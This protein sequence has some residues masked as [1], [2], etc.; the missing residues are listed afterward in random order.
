MIPA[1]GDL[2]PRRDG[3]IVVEV[4]M[5]AG[6]VHADLEELRDI[7][8]RLEAAE[9]DGNVAYIGD[10]MA[11]D[12]VIMVPNQDVREGK[13]E[14]ARFIGDILPGL[15]QHF[16]RRIIYVS[17]EVRVMA[18]GIAFDRGWFR[19]TAVPRSGGDATESTGKYF[20]LYTSAPGGS[21]KLF[22]LVHVLDEE[23]RGDGGPPSVMRRA[24]LAV[25]RW[26]QRDR[27]LPC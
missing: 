17:D 16:D 7:H 23:E 11:D 14:C 19:F 4:I 5:A 18:D 15:L 10:M 2:R 9:N 25:S 12:A 26:I 21:W 3:P 13:A 1:A 27:A 24:L 6:N 20:W 8:D 22:R